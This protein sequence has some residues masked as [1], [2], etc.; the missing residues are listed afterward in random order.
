MVEVY[1]LTD[2]LMPILEDIEILSPSAFRLGGYLRTLN[3][4]FEPTGELPVQNSDGL[5]GELANNIY[6]RHYIRPY[7]G[8]IYG[9]HHPWL[10]GDLQFVGRLEFANQVSAL[11]TKLDAPFFNCGSSISEVM[12]QAD[13]SRF[14]F[15]CRSSSAPLLVYELTRRIRKTGLPFRLKC[16]ASRWQYTR[17][18]AC[19]LYVRSEHSPLI[20]SIVDDLKRFGGSMFRG[21]TPMFT[22]VLDAGIGFAIDPGTGQSFGEHRCRLVAE[23]LINSFNRGRSGCVKQVEAIREVFEMNN[24]STEAPHRPVGTRE[25]YSFGS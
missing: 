11:G 1:S 20:H 5:L 9:V 13:L 7:R 2:E 23:G 16:L 22:Q 21:T 15:H 8:A 10:N 17:A 12:A 25:G 18:D 4:A 24:V 19:T 14:Y 3:G 6:S